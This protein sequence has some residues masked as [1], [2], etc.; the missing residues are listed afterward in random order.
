MRLLLIED[1]VALTHALARGLRELAHAVDVASDGTRGA[2]LATLNP[3][4]VIVLDVMLPGLDGMVLARALRARDNHTPIL[5]LT[6]RDAVQDRINGL[7][8]G[9]DDYLTKPFDFGELTA[10]L[11]ALA[12]R[13]AP[14]LPDRVVVRDLI[15][16]VRRQVAERGGRPIPLTAKE[17]AVLEFLA[18]HAG[19]VV[20]RAEITDHVWDENHDPLSNSLEVF[21]SRL[22]RKIDDGA[23][24]PLLYTRR[25]SGYLLA[26]LEAASD[27]ARASD[28]ARTG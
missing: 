15:I 19:R 14:L 26:D 1:D 16:D 22:R 9:G 20:S 28:G 5:F 25:R 24:V 12:R 3:Y 27:T 10:R 18:R 2:Y 6:A 13:R 17:Y 8:S 23:A 11:R 4:D 21:I 7:D